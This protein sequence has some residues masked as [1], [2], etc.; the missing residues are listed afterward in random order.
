MSATSCLLTFPSGG[1]LQSVR[2]GVRS[3]VKIEEALVS[4]KTLRPP[5][6]VDLGMKRYYL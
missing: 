3:I 4:S 2:I 5:F 1:S 6:A